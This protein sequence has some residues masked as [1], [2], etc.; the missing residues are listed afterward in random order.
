MKLSNRGLKKNQKQNT[1]K[2]T[3]TQKYTCL[4]TGIPLKHK[5][6]VITYIQKGPIK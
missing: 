4:H 5:K 6:E 2:H 3:Q 1:W